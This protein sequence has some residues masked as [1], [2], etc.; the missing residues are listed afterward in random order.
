IRRHPELAVGHMS[1]H[2]FRHSAAT[3]VLEGGA[4]LRVV[5]ELLGHASLNTTQIY[6]HVGAERLK[7]AYRQPHPRTGDELRVP[8]GPSATGAP[9]P[10]PR[11]ETDR[12]S[13]SA[14]LCP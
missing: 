14:H 2:G 8:R 7:A 4:D 1:P 10:S 12:D 5:Q 6:T 3:A 11:A 13:A 9:A